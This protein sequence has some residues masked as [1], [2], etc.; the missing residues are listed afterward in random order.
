M[1]LWAEH[2]GVLEDT[3]K[4]PQTLTCMRRVNEVGRE[5]WGA[6]VT[7][8]N[9]QLEMRG[10]LMQYPI[11]VG[12]DGKVTALPGHDTFPDVGGKVG[13]APTT[14]PDALTT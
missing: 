4:E 3:Y 14:L 12:R 9:D 10:H 6:Y 5:N 7:D 11:Q 8:G 1:S 13:G 2:L